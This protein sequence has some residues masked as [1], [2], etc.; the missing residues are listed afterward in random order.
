VIES[1][2]SKGGMGFDSDDELDP[3]TISE[4]AS[5]IAQDLECDEIPEGWEKKVDPA[6]NIAYYVN[7]ITETSQWSRPSSPAGNHLEEEHHEVVKVIDDERRL[8]DSLSLMSHDGVSHADSA[9]HSLSKR[10]PLEASDRLESFISTGIE[11]QE[12]DEQE[13]KGEGPVDM[14]DIQPSMSEES[15]EPEYPSRKG[16]LQKQG[17]L[18]GMWSKKFFLLEEGVLSFYESSQAYLT[19]A[20]PSKQMLLTASTE[21]SYTKMSHCFKIKTDGVEFVLMSE[22]KDLMREWIA[23]LRAIV[24]ALYDA[25]IKGLMHSKTKK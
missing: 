2:R 23:D 19:G 24:T 15:A 8:F 3:D 1:R 17:G 4:L 13:T 25:R 14:K 9:H 6:T 10:G 20:R 22:N 21:L 11:E 18:F 16:I 5:H 7:T 12:E